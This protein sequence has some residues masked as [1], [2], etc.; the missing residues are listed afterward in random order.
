MLRKKKSNAKYSN[1]RIKTFKIIYENLKIN[2][3]PM[4]WKQQLMAQRERGACAGGGRSP[5]GGVRRW[6]RSP[7]GSGRRRGAV[8]GEGQREG[9]KREGSKAQDFQNE[10]KNLFSFFLNSIK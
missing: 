8:A 9:S 7:A 2:L 3:L 6:G 4:N 5:V 1:C 10:K